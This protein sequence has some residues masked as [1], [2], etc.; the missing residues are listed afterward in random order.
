MKLLTYL[1]I[2]MTP[3]YMTFNL[4]ISVG[5][6][7]VTGEYKY[8]EHRGR[9]HPSDF[10]PAMVQQQALFISSKQGP[11]KVEERPVPNPS[12]GEVLVKIHST[13]R[14]KTPSLF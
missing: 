10:P 6:P 12:K 11:W 13:G 7:A 8:P 3:P 5:L 9:P 14:E 2:E 4:V 1:K